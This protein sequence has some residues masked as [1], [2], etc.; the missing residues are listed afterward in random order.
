MKWIWQ[1]Y[2][3]T[4][5]IPLVV[6]ELVFI[7]IYFTASNWMQK[8]MTG[9]LKTQVD[10]E[11]SQ[12]AGLEA[13]NIQQQLCGVSD[14][15]ELF[16]KQIKVALN[17]PAGLSGEDKKRLAYSTGGAYY[18][19]SDTKEGS[20]AVFYSG[21]VPVGETQ[22]AKVARV[23]QAQELIKNIQQSHS[24]A[25]S[26]YLNTFDSLNVIYPYFDVISQYPTHMDIPAYNFYY[27][28]DAKHNPQKKP[29]WTDVYLDPAGHGWMASSIA[30]VYN[31]DFLEGVVGIDVTVS[32]ITGQ[33]LNM[34][35]PWGGYGILLSN[36]G[37]ILALPEEGEK[38][39]G[40]T[41]LTDHHYDEAIKQDTFKPDQFN[42][43][44][45]KDL[46]G[47]AGKLQEN[48]S[49]LSTVMINNDP[50]VVSWQ[51][52]GETGWKY[53]VIV[54]ESNI[55]AKVNDMS[56]NLFYIGLTMIGGLIVFYCVFFY[57]LYKRS[58]RMSLN[59][60][61]PLVEINNMVERIGN[62]NYYQDEPDL[63]VKE[64]KD[65]AVLLTKMGRQLGI[66]NENLLETRDALEKREA[67]LQALVNSVDDVICE[68]DGNG[69]CS[70]V[71]AKEPCNLAIK[72]KKGE[73]QNIREIFDENSAAYLDKI[74][75]VIETGEPETIE[76]RCETIKG[77]R[78][79][80]AR[81]GLVDNG[82]DTVVVSAR[83][84]TE[85]KEME[86]SLIIAKDEAEKA[87][88]AKSQFLSS[89]SH[90]LRTPLNAVLGFAQILEMDSAAPLDESQ[91]ESV[92]EIKKAGNHLLE[93]INE[94][95][96]LS[97]IESGEM[98]ISIEPVRID[99]I[100]EETLALVK[101][102]AEKYG[103]TVETHPC[104]DDNYVLADNLRI[105]QVLIN[106]L[107]NAVKYNKENGRV[108]Y[109]CEKAGGNIRFYVE[110]TGKGIPKEEIEA[111]FEPFHRLDATRSVEEGTGIGLTLVKQLMQLMG[112]R[113]G[114]E[115]EE[116]RGSRFW[117]ELPFAGQVPV[118]IGGEHKKRVKPDQDGAGRKKV[119]YI[120]D[121]RA[122]L[123]LVE[124][125]LEHVDGISVI[126]A[127]S[128][129]V[130]I[131]LARAHCPDLILLDINLPVIDGFKVLER[132]RLY[133]ETKGIPVIAISA[134][135]MEK[136]IRRGMAK[137]FADYITKPIN[138]PDFIDK[139]NRHLFADD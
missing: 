18:T 80:Q 71:R 79:F 106:L 102:I 38:D 76:Y 117:I 87:S 125:I 120:E 116:G 86:Q 103:I 52:I 56:A 17:T 33:L 139:I 31:G 129:E 111:I 136:D 123:M 115:S 24:L 100:M 91:K 46:S 10:D 27:E 19:V 29:V 53:L 64:L 57:V 69:V 84:I 133:E 114:V 97:K 107:S 3:R 78:W 60:S 74:K 94:V 1:S 50:K 127:A 21:I 83:D 43:Y 128:G 75:K 12:I 11:L 88:Q 131:E 68:V 48:P 110:D 73:K 135:A 96:D 54:P 7:G 55:Y 62:G 124:R 13:N 14:A 8:E 5:L 49:G 36:D 104:T 118:H 108:F 67:Y 122:N 109:A 45:M 98:K 44:K 51:T 82:S 119:L 137:G 2:L 35:I 41:E 15:T 42:L 81:M 37:T 6:V 93:L 23:L 59:I 132:L 20:A 112:G 92:G 40:L 105:K 101:P 70:N 126:P 9:S 72:Y 65:T 25:A 61:K 99:L 63:Q 4:A 30:P 32:N 28:A 34:D 22:R 138:V 77:I 90:E 58:R 95:L 39:W 66:A 121:N 26:V 16:A 85:R 113:I 134:S 89:M 130:G 47:F